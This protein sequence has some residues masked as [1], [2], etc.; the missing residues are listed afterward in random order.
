MSAPT[1]C[2][3]LP[4]TTCPNSVSRPSTMTLINMVATTCNPHDLGVSKI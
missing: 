3:K 4:L 1:Y 2:A